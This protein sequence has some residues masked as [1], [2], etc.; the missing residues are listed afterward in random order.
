[1]KNEEIKKIIIDS[2]A[3]LTLAEAGL[4]F[5]LASNINQKGAIVEI[6]SFK[7]GS[8]IF[9]AKGAR[10]AKKGKVYAIDPFSDFSNCQF[11][12]FFTI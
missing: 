9:L 8:T 12:F 7:G 5:S 11:S 1:M 4:L 6:G 3:M 10:I 2:H